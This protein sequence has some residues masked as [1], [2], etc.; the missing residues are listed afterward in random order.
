VFCAHLG[1]LFVQHYETFF[2]ILND[3]WPVLYPPRFFSRQSQRPQTLGF[4][5]LRLELSL[6]LGSPYLPTFEYGFRSRFCCFVHAVIPPWVAVLRNWSAS[7]RD[8]A[9]AVTCALKI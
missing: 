8:D 2:Y 6:K 3:F 1:C 7:G 4:I 9:S 5:P